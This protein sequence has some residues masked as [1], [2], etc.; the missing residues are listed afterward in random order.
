MTQTVTSIPPPL[1]APDRYSEKL[2]RCERF[3]RETVARLTGHGKLFFRRNGSRWLATS[4]LGPKVNS[5]VPTRAIIHVL[6]AFITF[7]H[8]MR[9]VSM[10][11]CGAADVDPCACVASWLDCHLTD[12]SRL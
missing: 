4:A 6:A 12:D 3:D 9:E 8:K 5:V 10:A 11:H 2:K 1:Q 7:R